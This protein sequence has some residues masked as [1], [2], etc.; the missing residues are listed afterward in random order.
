MDIYSYSKYTYCISK[1]INKHK[2]FAF[3]SF[4]TSDEICSAVES[5]NGLK[6]SMASSVFVRY[7]TLLFVD[8]YLRA[9]LLLLKS[10][11]VS[12]I[13]NLKG[14]RISLRQLSY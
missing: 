14:C 4:S 5:L 13:V 6:T 1:I 3:V 10:R 12:K 8:M 7:M 11:M 2:S 9:Q